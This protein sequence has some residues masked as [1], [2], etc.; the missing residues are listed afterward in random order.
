M[1]ALN[2]SLC[3]KCTYNS[4]CSISEEHFKLNRL[5]YVVECSEYCYANSDHKCDC[6]DCEIADTC[7]YKDKYQR[8]DRNIARGAL[9]LCKKL[10]RRL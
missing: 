10:E 9:S 4:S 3:G 1:I 7:N 8:L 6:M 2:G 5:G